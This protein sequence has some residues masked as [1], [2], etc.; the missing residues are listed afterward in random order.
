MTAQTTMLESQE[1]PRMTETSPSSSSMSLQKAGSLSRVWPPPPK[2]NNVSF[3]RKGSSSSLVSPGAI[4][5]TD[6]PITPG[7][8]RSK[9]LSLQALF[10]PRGKLSN[11]LRTPLSASSAACPAGP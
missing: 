6:V 7:S 1:S 4:R 5:P 3:S 11:K 9:R 2:N 8:V 10:T